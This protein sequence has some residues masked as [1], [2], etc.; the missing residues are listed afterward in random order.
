MEDELSFS[1]LSVPLK[2]ENLK[3]KFSHSCFLCCC[4]FHP[5]SFFPV[6]RHF[7]GN[8]MTFFIP[9]AGK[10]VHD[11]SLIRNVHTIF[12]PSPIRTSADMAAYSLHVH[13]L[14]TKKG[15]GRQNAIPKKRVACMCRYNSVCVS[16]I[17]RNFVDDALAIN[18]QIASTMA[19]W[20]R[21]RPW[22]TICPKIHSL[23]L[24]VNVHV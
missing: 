2:Q 14:F 16:E 19:K 4:Y 7:P 8:M 1:I 5:Q 17:G 18:W 12:S 24:L 21:Q 11:V 3:V 6:R 20:Q 9:A 15:P 13:T 22:N 23:S 10:Q